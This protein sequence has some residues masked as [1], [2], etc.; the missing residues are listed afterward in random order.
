MSETTKAPEHAALTPA[1]SAAPSR[2]RPI[3]LRVLGVWLTVLAVLAGTSAAAAANSDR[4]PHHEPRPVALAG[5]WDVTVN[6][7]TPDG[8]VSTTTPRFVFRADHQLTATGPLDDAGVPI[9]A[10]TGFWNQ[11]SDGS[12]VFYVTHG[13]VA[14]GGAVPGVVQAVHI[15]KI[16]G[17]TFTTAAYAFVTAEPGQPLQGPIS[18]D[19]SATWI[20][21]LPAS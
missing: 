6:V 14:E 15:G 20:S 18:V 1:P 2:P 16:T 7:H 12:F 21:A 3:A 13:G 19:S 9:Y 11:N 8:Q 4:R 10:A 17:K 5:V